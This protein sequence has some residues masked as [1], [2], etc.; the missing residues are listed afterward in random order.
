MN[1]E[2][3]IVV[4]VVLDL[5]KHWVL[6]VKAG[7]DRRAERDTSHKDVI[8][9]IHLIPV[10]KDELSSPIMF[11]RQIIYKSYSSSQF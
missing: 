2:F 5:K 8:H 6:Q 1:P 7:T 10:P 9:H 4:V 3:V 11:Y